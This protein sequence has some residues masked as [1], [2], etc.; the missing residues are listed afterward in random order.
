RLVKAEIHQVIDSFASSMA[1]AIES[2][3]KLLLFGTDFLT[4]SVS[5]SRYPDGQR[6]RLESIDEGIVNDDKV[7][8]DEDE[9]EEICA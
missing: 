2:D 5:S 1:K 7:E 9:I 6:V 8:D 3:A 4:D